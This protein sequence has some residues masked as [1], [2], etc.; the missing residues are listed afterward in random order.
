MRAINHTVTGA[1][2]GAA[3]G[4]PWIALPAA[5]LSHLVLDFIPHY[6]DERVAH[7]SL[8]FKLELAIDAALAAGFLLALALLQPPDWQLLIACGVLGAA[9][10]LWW[11]PYWVVELKTGKL[12]PYDPIGKI[13]EKIQWAQRPWGIYIESVWLVGALYAFFALT[14]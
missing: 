6:D 4:N 8:R 12:L 9:P 2:I 11:F 10:D 14:A 5:L 13:L 7:T 1:A 3:V